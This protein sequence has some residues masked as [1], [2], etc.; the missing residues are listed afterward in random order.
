MFYDAYVA[1]AA[2]EPAAA[3][4]EAITLTDRA[5]SHLVKLRQERAASAGGQEQQLVFR[6]RLRIIAGTTPAAAASTLCPVRS[7]KYTCSKHT[8]LDDASCSSSRS[9]TIQALPVQMADPDLDP[10]GVCSQPDISSHILYVHSHNNTS[11]VGVKQGGC[12]GLSYIMDFEQ[13]ENIKVRVY[14]CVCGGWPFVWG[15]TY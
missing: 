2:A 4:S 13:P 1:A 12:S 15:G 3:P 6:V 11:Q 7:S 14:V 10:K 8:M 5:L 9:S